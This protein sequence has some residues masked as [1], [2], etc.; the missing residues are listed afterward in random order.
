MDDSGLLFLTDSLLGVA[1]I[2]HLAA[3]ALLRHFALVLFALQVQAEVSLV[4]STRVAH[5]AIELPAWRHTHGQVT[6][7]SLPW[8]W[9][10]I[11]P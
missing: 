1:Q 2:L 3:V 9:V 4:T 7:D 6:W 5:G 10:V 8:P 11:R